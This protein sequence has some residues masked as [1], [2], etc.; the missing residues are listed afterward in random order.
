MSR[1]DDRISANADRRRLSESQRR[2]LSDRFIGQRAGPRDDSNSSFLMNMAR[3]D[4][5]LALSGRNYPGA[6]RA[7][8]PRAPVAEIFF[9]LYH[10]GDRDP[11]GDAN[12]QR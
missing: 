9:D 4:A 3:H 6:I 12:D 7:D 5:D 1:P 2:Q 11:F 8:H 10:V